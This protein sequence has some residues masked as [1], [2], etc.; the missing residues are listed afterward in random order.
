MTRC[1]KNKNDSAFN[2]LGY[3]YDKF[4]KRIETNFKDGMCWEN[5][6]EWHV[7]HKKPISRFNSNT[8]PHIVNAL[9]N[10]QPLWAKDNLS[11]GNKY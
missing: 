9:C 6:G 3:D 7:D 5:H 2:I 8:P 10:L 1:G 11:K 4:K